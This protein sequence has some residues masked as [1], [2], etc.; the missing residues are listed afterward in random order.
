MECLRA[1]CA[2]SSS[3][4]SSSTALLVTLATGMAELVVDLG[5]ASLASVGLMSEEHPS[6][7]LG[8]K[9]IT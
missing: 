3:S 4:S 5:L 9:L 1:S 6:L 2:K 7:D 8:L